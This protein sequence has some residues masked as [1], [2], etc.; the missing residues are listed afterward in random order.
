MKKAMMFCLLA[1]LVLTSLAVLVNAETDRE[2]RC[3]G[4]RC[5]TTMEMHH[6]MLRY[7]S[8]ADGEPLECPKNNRDRKGIKNFYRFSDRW[9]RYE[10]PHK[11]LCA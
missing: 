10:Q 7:I 11:W 3:S 1:L 2:T 9:V 4:D 8:D 6:G 5:M